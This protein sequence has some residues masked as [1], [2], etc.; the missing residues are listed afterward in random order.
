[1]FKT[2]QIK[3]NFVQLFLKKGKKEKMNKQYELLLFKIKK[4]KVK[5]GPQKALNNAVDM[6]LRPLYLQ[7]MT[8][9]RS[10]VKYQSKYKQIKASLRLLMT[11]KNLPKKIKQLNSFNIP[12]K[13]NKNEFKKMKSYKPFLNNVN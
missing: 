7:Q 8:K 10:I 13:L 1:M 12:R 9:Y 11:F 5:T 3:N 6:Y 2:N 4:Q